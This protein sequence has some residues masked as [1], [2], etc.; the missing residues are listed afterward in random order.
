VS[1]REPEAKLSRGVRGNFAHRSRVRTPL[2]S[3]AREITLD[4]CDV[5]ILGDEMLAEAEMLLLA[6]EREARALV[7]AVE[8]V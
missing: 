4:L 7:M 6:R 5:P 1:E 3:R 2:T 8:S